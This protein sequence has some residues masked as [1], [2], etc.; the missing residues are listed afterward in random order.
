MRA[1]PLPFP[2][3]LGLFVLVL[4]LPGGCARPVTPAPHVPARAPLPPLGP[5]AMLVPE[6]ADLVV[7]VAPLTLMGAPAVRRVVHAVTPPEHLERF[8]RRT[9]I[10]P[11]ALTEAVVAEYP[12]GFVALLRGGVDA[13]AH[14]RGV[15]SHMTPVE[16]SSDAPFLRRGGHV[17]TV[18]REL[19]A[20]RPDVLAVAGGRTRLV[21][22]ELVERA[23]R[24]HWASSV[25]SAFA[26]RDALDLRATWKGTPAAV[27]SLQPLDL[28]P[29]FG[30]SVLLARERTL[31]LAIRPAG[32]DA[33]AFSVD[34][35]GEFPE[36][37]GDNF[38]QLV[39][40]VAASD[41]GGALGLAEGLDSLGIQSEA[42]RVVLRML[43][44]AAS[45]A[46][47]LTLL[48]GADVRAV[49]GGAQGM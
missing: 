24:G 45:L 13:V 47:G 11:T 10:D 40:S 39:K 19:V 31:A 16:L 34:L 25:H 20:L 15:A 21:M 7:D 38:R 28:P 4:V 12:D 18:W 37:A 6:G 14:V 2:R 8:S 48:F 32:P 49:L 33:L 26:T 30:A 5:L 23:A 22:A 1:D 35:R 41:L 9:G 29:G 3:V 43:V 42:D 36:G 46:G 17:G 44:P 27:Y